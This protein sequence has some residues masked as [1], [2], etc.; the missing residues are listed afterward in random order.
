MP[1]RENISATI[2]IEAS[3]TVVWEIISDLKRMGEWSPQCR[4]MI[5]RDTP[6]GLGTRTL[7]FNNQGALWWPTRSKVIEF[8]PERR[9]AFKVLEN[10]SV[11]TY[12]LE[13][14]TTGTRV[15]ETRTIP[16]GVTGLS[17]FLV[18]RVMGGAEAFEKGLER[19]MGKTLQRIKGEAEHVSV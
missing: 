3:P 4:K 2:E 15:T 1:N 18:G 7:N 17:K 11:W 12:E 5:V 9:L 8:I 13:P 6:V 14:T 19:G 16:H 10:H